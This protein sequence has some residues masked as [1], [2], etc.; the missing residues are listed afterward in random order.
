MKEEQETLFTVSR[1][2][3]DGAQLDALTLPQVN[4]ICVYIQH[5]AYI[6]DITV[7]RSG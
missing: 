3:N 2:R 5:L 6:K 1:Q 7:D 4:L